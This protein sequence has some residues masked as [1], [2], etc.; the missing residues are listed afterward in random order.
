MGVIRIYRPSVTHWCKV[1]VHTL[2]CSCDRA[3]FPIF[4]NNTTYEHQTC[5]S[6]LLRTCRFLESP[7]PGPSIYWVMLKLIKAKIHY[8][9][10]EGKTL[11]KICPCPSV[12]KVVMGTK[13]R[14][15]TEGS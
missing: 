11:I 12:T 5:T 14:C 3:V 15:G 10:R 6:V 13:I 8:F 2:C 1:G 9:V 7:Y 4:P